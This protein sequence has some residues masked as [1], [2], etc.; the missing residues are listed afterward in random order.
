MIIID[1]IV[2]KVFEFESEDDAVAYLMDLYDKMSS[3]VVDVKIDAN[4]H[5]QGT[6]V[7]HKGMFS[8]NSVIY[9]SNGVISKY[10]T[11]FRNSISFL[12]K[13]IRNKN[14]QDMYSFFKMITNFNIS[15]FGLISKGD[16]RD[17][18]LNSRIPSDID[19]NGY[20][21]IVDTFS[22]EDFKGKGIGMC[23]EFSTVTNIVLSLFGV[24]CYYVCGDYFINGKQDAHAYNILHL[25]DGYYILDTSN[26]HCMYNSS[27]KLVHCANTIKKINDDEFESLINEGSN[28]E[29]PM[30]NCICDDNSKSWKKIDE[31]IGVYSCYKKNKER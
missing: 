27:G 23:T 6:A 1:D 15:Y 26:P 11:D 2:K 31:T 5:S 25:S 13:Y 20:F 18:F 22:I 9:F 16:V 10:K 24:D 19:D 17:D 12:V 30:F 28:I 21:R 3:S 8:R 4:V 7:Y 29:V 14:I